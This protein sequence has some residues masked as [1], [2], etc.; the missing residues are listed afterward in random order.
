MTPALPFDPGMMAGPGAVVLAVVLGT[1]VSED[2]TC[3]AVGLLAAAGR[4]DLP[5]GLTGCFL[6]IVLGDVGVWLVGRVAGRR[7]LSWRWGRRVLPERR[8]AGLSGLLCRHGGRAAVVSRFLPGTRVPLFLAAGVLGTCWYR[9]L[10][11]AV[12][13]AAVWTPLL[14]LSV[15]LLGDALVGPLRQLSGAG[16]VVFPAVALALYLGLR[17]VPKLAT[18]GGRAAAAARLG[19]LR[20]L[21]FWPAW[22]F[23]LPV[24]PWWI[25]LAVRYR[26]LT[27]W[28][29]ANPGIPAGGVVGESK[30]EILSKLPPEWTVPT[31]LVP[32]GEAGGRVRLARAAIAAR[33]WSYPLVLKPDAGQRGAGV[34]LC[35]DAVEVEKYLRVNPDPVIAQPYHPGPFEAGVFYY[36]VPG[37]PAGHIFSVTDKVFPVAVGDG[38][39]TLEELVRRHPRY[40][41]QAGTFLARLA[42]DRDRV[43]DDGERVPL[44]L[45]G[46]HCQGTLFRDGGHLF[47]PALERRIDEIARAFDGFYFGRF[48]VRYADEAEFRAGRGFAVVELNGVTSESTD[49]YDPLWPPWLVYRTLY[50]QWALLF[51]IGRENRRRGHRP[52]GLR[53]LFGLLARHYRGRTVDP[54]AD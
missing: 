51:R 17:L 21:E 41:L 27:V 23:Y 14:V 1:F 18:P 10:G 9:F 39:S 32:A 36:R 6:G 43:P 52:V 3:V 29:A 53:E 13:A 40:R 7:V 11:W 22:V 42:A 37:E 46:N 2:L 15:A 19:R 54:L 16:W 50:R 12:F 28:T 5:V 48:D 35:R 38:R 47:T 34:K 49:V 31:L 44:A 30:A 25:W 4:V 45:A 8:L 26:T 20:R 33:G 24:V